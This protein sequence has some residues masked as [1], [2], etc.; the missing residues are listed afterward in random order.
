MCKPLY[1]Y[2]QEIFFYYLRWC[3]LLYHTILAF[4]QRL[5]LLLYISQNDVIHVTVTR[6]P[7][8]IARYPHAILCI[9]YYAFP[10]THS[11]PPIHSFTSIHTIY[12][13]PLPQ[14]SSTST[15]HPNLYAYIYLLTSSLTTLRHVGSATSNDT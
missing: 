7:P 9:H 3:W 12:P 15:H 14:S 1:I 6:S 5:L 4:Q 13:L 11:F 10:R 2:R 8:P